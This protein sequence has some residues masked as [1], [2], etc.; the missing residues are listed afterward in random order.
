MQNNQNLD[1]KLIGLAVS[2]LLGMALAYLIVK[3]A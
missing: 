3:L 1:P 2:I